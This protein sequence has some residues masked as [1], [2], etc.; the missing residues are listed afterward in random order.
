M[1]R[2]DVMGILCRLICSINLGLAVGILLPVALLSFP[3]TFVEL[4]AIPFDEAF[5]PGNAGF[6]FAQILLTSVT[7]AGTLYL[8]IGRGGKHA[9]VLVASLS[10]IALIAL[11]LNPYWIGYST[12]LQSI[13]ALPIYSRGI[14]PHHH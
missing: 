3:S 14:S 4:S 11:V 9:A 1:S 8:S 12:L 7:A 6:I 13:L 2:V 5:S 10:I